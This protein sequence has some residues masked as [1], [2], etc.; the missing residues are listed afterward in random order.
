MEKS[1]QSMKGG[2]TNTMEPD[3]GFVRR[4]DNILGNY[5]II[6]QK[7]WEGERYL[8]IIATSKKRVDKTN[9]SLSFIWVHDGG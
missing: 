5:G 7:V 4:D 1:E 8:K 3:E 9:Q 2:S 6:K